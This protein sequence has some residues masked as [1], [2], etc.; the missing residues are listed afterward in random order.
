MNPVKPIP[1]NAGHHGVHFYTD[2]TSLCV[3]VCDFICDGLVADQPVL[4]IATPQHRQLISAQLALRRFDVRQ[5]EVQ[6]K[7]MFFDAQRTMNQFISSGVIDAE[8]FYTVIGAAI[9]DLC[10]GRT[11]CTVRAYGEMVD[12][13]WRGGRTEQA[14]ELELLWNQLAS[15]H[16]FSL[17]CGYAM[18]NFY[19]E[20]S[21][22]DICAMHSHVHE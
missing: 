1:G 17:L 5:L 8:R 21:R 15:R 19:K 3:S 10:A 9:V 18:G 22:A 16:A 7:A 11:D 6:Q 20:N 12:V 2:E 14:I 4:I 13:L